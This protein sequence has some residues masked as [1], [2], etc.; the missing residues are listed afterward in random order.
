MTFYVSNDDI[1]LSYNRQKIISQYQSTIQFI[2][3]KDLTANEILVNINQLSIFDNKTTVII[4]N[5]NILNKVNADTVLKFNSIEKNI[6]I[7]INLGA[8]EKINSTL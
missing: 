1:L 2:D 5:G 3:A 7:F 4:N 8:R 6:F